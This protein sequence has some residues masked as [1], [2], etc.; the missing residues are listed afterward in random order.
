MKTSTSTTDS[1]SQAFLTGTILFA[2]LDY[3]ALE[4]YAIK[5]VIGGAIWMIF[6]L[7]GD[8]LSHKILKKNET[9]NQTKSEHP[10]QQDG[11]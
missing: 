9:N 10:K 3:S 1:T 11:E 6:K 5:A 4:A 7:A 8:Y 2:N